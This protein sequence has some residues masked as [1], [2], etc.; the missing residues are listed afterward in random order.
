MSI[1]PLGNN[2]IFLISQPRAGSTLLQ[3]ILA[4]HPQIGTTPEPWL[5]LHP[6]YALRRKGV[7]TEYFFN[8]YRIAFGAFLQTFPE[9]ERL[10]DEAVRAYAGTLYNRACQHLGVPRFLDKTPSYTLIIPELYRIFPQARFIFLLRN[11][12]AVLH[13]ILTTWVRNDYT[14]MKKHRYSL[15]GAPR[16]I[17]EGIQLLGDQA[18]IVRYETLVTHPEETVAD[19][20]RQ[21]GVKYTPAMLEYRAQLP[22]KATMGDPTGV[23]R[24][25]RP[26][27]HSLEAWR[28]LTENAQTLHFA[29]AYLQALGADTLQALGYEYRGLLEILQNAP[30]PSGR[31]LIRWERALAPRK[32]LPEKFRLLWHE[33]RQRKTWK[34]LPK[35]IVKLFIEES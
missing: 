8:R 35:R 6:V 25:Q 15:L 5:M 32:S 28:A 34:A 13:S 2:L 10:H 23:R 14:R 30:A 21:L 31:I 24:H 17:A 11:P 20:C 29:K 16:H 12:M 4:G 33:T 1:S 27:K 7:E 26:D 3:Y 19:L 18:L 9:G 22:A